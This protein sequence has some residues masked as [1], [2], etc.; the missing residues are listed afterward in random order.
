MQNVL[1]L[2][3]HCT[4][5]HVAHVC[6]VH[7]KPNLNLE[8]CP[9][10]RGLLLFRD[11]ISHCPLLEVLLTVHNYLHV[12]VFSD[13]NPFQNMY[14][15]FCNVHLQFLPGNMFFKYPPHSVCLLYCTVHTCT[16]H[17]QYMH[18]LY[19]FILLSL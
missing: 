3:V 10:L 17:V 4:C 14:M 18:V 9:L 6:H 12:H 11:P 7:R 2:H 19:C 1:K 15:C 8:E 5:S 13:N 16:L